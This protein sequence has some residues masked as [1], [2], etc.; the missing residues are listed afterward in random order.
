MLQTKKEINFQEILYLT[1]KQ[2]K[3]HFL[4]KNS[5][6]Q[7]K[8]KTIFQV[9]KYRLYFASN[10]V[11]GAHSE[12]TLWTHPQVILTALPVTTSCQLLPNIEIKC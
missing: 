1:L 2:K 5:D 4:L 6:Y 10:T 7:N 3:G 9:Q 12:N 11:P 8:W